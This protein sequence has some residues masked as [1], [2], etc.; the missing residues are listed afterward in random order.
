MIGSDVAIELILLLVA[1]HLYFGNLISPFLLLV[2]ALTD[3]A[4]TARSAARIT[5]ED[6]SQESAVTQAVVVVATEKDI[7]YKTEFEYPTG[8]IKGVEELEVP[9]TNTVLYIK[10][11][12][13]CFQKYMSKPSIFDLKL[14]L[15]DELHIMDEALGRQM[16]SPFQKGHLYFYIT[17][18]KDN[19]YIL[20]ATETLR[21]KG[22]I[23]LDSSKVL[24][25]NEIEKVELGGFWISNDGK[26]LLY[27]Y[28]LPGCMSCTYIRVRDVSTGIENE[29]D[30]LTLQ[31][32]NINH[33]NVVW[34]D[35]MSFKGFFYTSNI[36]VT[37]EGDQPSFATKHRVYFHV[38]G[39]KQ[40]DDVIVRESMEDNVYYLHITPDTKYLVIEVF[41]TKH[42]EKILTCEVSPNYGDV[43]NSYGNKVYYI[44]ISELKMYYQQFR[45]YMEQNINGTHTGVSCQ[46][47]CVKLID[48]YDYRFQYITSIEIDFWFRTNYD[49]PRYRVI[50]VTLP[51]ITSSHLGL[52]NLSKPLVDIAIP[53]K[54]I[55]DSV[56]TKE[57]IPM[58]K[59]GGILVC[60]MIAAH[61]VLVLKY[62]R[63]NSHE[64]L[65]FDL[66]QSVE[67]TPSAPV[68]ELPHP[69][70]GTITTISCSFYSFDIFYKFNN[71][72]DAGSIWRSVITRDAMS[73][74]I[75]ISFDQFWNDLNTR[76]TEEL[77]YRLEAFDTRREMYKSTDNTQIPILL[78]GKRDVLDAPGPHQPCILCTVGGFGLSIIPSF[79]S[80]FLI[81][82]Q[83]YNGI[84]AV[85]GI[86]GGGDYG[87]SWHRAGMNKNRSK[88]VDDI[89]SATEY[90]LENEFASKNSLTLLGEGP[91]GVV[92]LDV[93]NKRPFLFQSV[94]FNSGIFDILRY[95]HYNSSIPDSNPDPVLGAASQDSIDNWSDFSSIDN[96][97][98]F[99]I[100][101]SW[102]REY[103]CAEDSAYEQERSRATC[104]LNNINHD[105]IAEY[106]AIFL[107]AEK[108][109]QIVSPTHSTKLIYQ[110][111]NSIINTKYDNK[112]R[113]PFLLHYRENIPAKNDEMEK[114]AT[115]LALLCNLIAAPQR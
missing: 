51:E 72:S 24:L 26:K 71:F 9:S 15:L 67:G 25:N 59:D 44:D 110:L 43:T 96:E 76:L 49:A 31:N 65:I 55:L 28:S 105:L 106:P 82:A 30:H 85:A 108:N 14:K 19:G 16:D 36:S 92:M 80:T 57:W 70:Y 4:K 23:V 29:G 46:M 109:N 93:I 34:L 87:M 64:I 69:P 60:G 77:E 111:Q 6:V 17:K 45:L 61:T 112:K 53:M 78:F 2:T 74:S 81:W 102:Y 86:R 107:I 27:T 7:Q 13:K 63:E 103:G 37:S 41:Q 88:A 42:I 83:Q 115:I 10:E 101:N 22:K 32:N 94:I 50:L 12:Q 3:A 5:T 11:Q 62:L 40:S 90:L 100:A 89:V 114:H 68:A 52:L 95:H 79:S 56:N 47:A 58:A 54:F 104:P 35:N 75:E 33:V 1:L 18:N 20:Y 48:S 66:S 97:K 98:H 91:A 39:T 8:A 99:A 73:G 113:L 21:D 84:I 38:L